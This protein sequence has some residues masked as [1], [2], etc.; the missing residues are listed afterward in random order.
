MHARLTRFA[1]RTRP[2]GLTLVELLV[3][4]TILG[5]VTAATI[6]LMQ[7]PSA[8]PKVREAAREFSATLEQARALAISTGRPA[9]VRIEFTTPATGQPVLAQ[10]IFLCEV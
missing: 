2:T 4:I 5:I 1:T 8:D 3:V 9:G 10:R 7:P 6:P